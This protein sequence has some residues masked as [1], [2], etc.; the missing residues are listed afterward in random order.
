MKKVNYWGLDYL[1]IECIEDFEEVKKRDKR[2]N[3]KYILLVIGNVYVGT[4]ESDTIKEIKFDKSGQI[5]HIDDLYLSSR[6]KLLAEYLKG[7]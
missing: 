1:E 3:Y 2:D 4:I 7:E 6:V 5:I